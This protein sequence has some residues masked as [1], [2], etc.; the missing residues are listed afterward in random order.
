MIKIIEEIEELNNK[1]LNIK[2]KGWIKTMRNGP[3]GIG[4][5]FERLLGKKEENFPIPDYKNLEIKTSRWTSWG[6]I[7]LFH[8]T[9]DGDYLF[10]IKDIIRVLGYPDKDY[11]EYMVFNASVNAKE[12]TKI[13]YH[14]RIKLKVNSE[15]EKIDLIAKDEHNNNYDL[16]ISW[17]FDMLKKKN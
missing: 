10:P 2:E 4:Y 8:A 13:G 3:G 17:S 16:H 7:H 12:Y 1:F 6:K 11:P 9:P 14:K 15:K 5:T